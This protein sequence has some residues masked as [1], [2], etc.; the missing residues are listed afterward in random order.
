MSL[1]WTAEQPP[2]WD[3]EKQRIVGGVPEGSLKIEGFSEGDSVPGEWWRVERDGRTI[4]YGWMDTTWDGAEILLAVDPQAQ[5]GGVGA[6]ILDQLDAETS[7]KGLNY[8]FNVVQA[9]PP[10]REAVTAWLEAHGF[11]G[12]GDGQLKRHVKRG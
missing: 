10:R 12:S 1:T 4:G 2:R 3:A 8:M 9:A 6:F 7:E 11:E 5:G